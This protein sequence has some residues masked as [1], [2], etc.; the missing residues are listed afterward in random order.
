MNSVISLQSASH[1]GIEWSS[2]GSAFPNKRGRA[3]SQLEPQRR[4][5]G[6]GKHAEAHSADVPRPRRQPIG[7]EGPLRSTLGDDAKAPNA[8]GVERLI[9]P[10]NATVSGHG[11]FSNEPSRD[12]KVPRD[13][14]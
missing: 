14:C 10:P 3:T 4:R 1:E 7:Q 12:E 9:S 6:L 5:L 2:V 11:L 8:A 13:S